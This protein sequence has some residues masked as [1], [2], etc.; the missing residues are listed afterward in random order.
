MNPFRVITD[1]A[2]TELESGAIQE[3]VTAFVKESHAK[4]SGADEQGMYQ[5]TIETIAAL[6]ILNNNSGQF[7]L[8]DENGKVMSYAL[9]HVAK[10]VDN[11]LCYWMTQAWVNPVLRGKP[12]VKQM[13]RRLIEEA[14]RLM[15][16]HIIIPSSREPKSYCRFLG[17]G[18]SPYLTLLKVDL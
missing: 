4:E 16:K 7:W 1:L 12:I 2:T 6:T 13:Y 15:C 10:D 3:A 9:T 8:S 17:K 18:W 11:Q 5:Q 14:K